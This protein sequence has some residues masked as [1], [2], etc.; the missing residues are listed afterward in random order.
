MPVNSKSP[1]AKLRLQSLTV[2]IIVSNK[3]L[4]VDH[5]INNFVSIQRNKSAYDSLG[6]SLNGAEAMLLASAPQVAYV[7][8]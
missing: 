6:R 8:G 3:K 7:S 4:T 5:F 2:G 1:P